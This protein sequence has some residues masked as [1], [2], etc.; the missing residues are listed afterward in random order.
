METDSTLD[1]LEILSKQR[2]LAACY[3]LDRASATLFGRAGSPCL[4]SSTI[5]DLP[6]PWQQRRWDTTSDHPIDPPSNRVERLSEFW[7]YISTSSKPLHQPLDAFSSQLLLTALHDERFTPEYEQTGNTSILHAI[8]TS[9]HTR[10]TYHTLMLCKTTPIRELLGVAGEGWVTGEELK[11]QS[12]YTSAQLEVKQWAGQRVSNHSQPHN[13][14]GAL[15]HAFPILEIFR[16]DP[17]SGVL[18]QEWAV[19]LASLVIWARAYVLSNGRTCNSNASTQSPTIPQST[20][21]EDLEKA[22][23]TFLRSGSKTNITWTECRNTLLWVRRKLK[24]SQELGLVAAA[25]Q[26]LGKLVERGG[27]EGWL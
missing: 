27:D 16:N 14:H 13:V 18:Y 15:F 11:S 10:L 2:L 24:A 5:A 6:F 19:Y 3:I 1:N 8:E 21:E 7:K 12:D 25:L 22:M 26:V 17:T 23:A 9:P 20:S 4:R